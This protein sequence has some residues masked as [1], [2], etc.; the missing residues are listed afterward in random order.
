[1]A[2][3]N[4]Q[5]FEVETVK[6]DTPSGPQY[7]LNNLE[8][9]C[10][11]S[12]GGRLVFGDHLGMIRTYDRGM[13]CQQFSAYK[14][15]VTHLHQIKSVKYLVSIG[16][17][18]ETIHEQQQIKVKI[19]TLDRGYDQP[20]PLQVMS[21]F[22]QSYPAPESRRLLLNLNPN[23]DLDYEIPNPD[24]DKPPSIIK[25]SSLKSP[26]T[27]LDV[28]EDLR[29]LAVGLTNGDVILAKGHLINGLRQIQLRRVA[30][31]TSPNKDVTF[32]QFRP[33]PS[34][35]GK[36]YSYNLH[37]VYYDAGTIWTVG[38]S[39]NPVTLE[40]QVTGGLPGNSCFSPDGTLAIAQ[41]DTLHFY[42]G[43][44]VQPGEQRGSQRPANGSVAKKL[45]LFRNYYYVVAKMDKFEKDQLTIYDLQNR[46]RATL[47]TQCYIPNIVCVLVEW[48]NIFVL[49]QEDTKDG[50]VQQRLFQLEEKDTQTKLDLLF[51]TKKYS[52]A[53]ELAKAQQFDNSAVTEI[54]RKFGDYLY[55]KSDY[56]GAVR[57]Y[58]ATIGL[59]E[60][61]Y[62]IRK[63]LDAQQIPHLT[64]YLEELHGRRDSADRPLA[65]EDHTTLLLN[66]YT[67]Q[68]DEQ[69]LNDF[70]GEDR[71]Y[72]PETAIKV[73]RQAGYYN[74]ALNLARKFK[75]HSLYLS[76]QVE[77]LKHYEEA[78][79]YIQ[80][81]DFDDAERQL[82]EYGKTL[83]S[84][85]PMKATEL[86]R[87]ICTRWK[88]GTASE[89]SRGIY[90]CSFF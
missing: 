52:V 28:T 14:G 6:E 54:Y 66:C 86:L 83:V 85:K 20:T 16:D 61:S 70:I 60:P 87:E 79:T 46:I 84:K 3:T 10:W 89:P 36:D 48:S 81:L 27:C 55:Q 1:M 22:N 40:T 8:C 90:Y 73:L 9:I 17:D 53:I 42:G 44:D 33:N 15:P 45:G 4:L 5:F 57:Q 32:L 39:S 82:Q 35:I 58:V 76:V 2:L 18:R 80:L 72:N 63:F 13:K 41:N 23:I 62:V 38:G 34:N 12:G 31:S 19:W 26:V 71:A 47:S 25:Q 64:T 59:L 88:H 21:L 50:K 30:E 69:K 24:S 75:E 74:H 37:V 11:T 65:N 77:D 51:S 68:K 49:H 7:A 43:S 78:L 29:L 56:S 67:K